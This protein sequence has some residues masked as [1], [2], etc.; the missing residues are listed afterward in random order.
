M[1]NITETYTITVTKTNGTLDNSINIDAFILTQPEDT[2]VKITTPG[3][4][5]STLAPTSAS[6]PLSP[7]FVAGGVTLT[8]VAGASNTAT[9][10]SIQTSS[11]TSDDS[12]STSPNVA[13]I[14]GGILGGVAF[15]I[16]VAFFVFRWWSKRDQ[17]RRG[18]VGPDGLPIT[19]Y[20][21]DY[22][23]NGYPNAAPPYPTKHRGGQ[24]QSRRPAVVDR[25]RHRHRHRHHHSVPSTF[26]G[27]PAL[28]TPPSTTPGQSSISGGMDM[29]QA[30]RFPYI[31][32]MRGK[33]NYMGSMDSSIPPSHFLSSSPEDTEYEGAML[34]AYSR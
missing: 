23:R 8:S 29:A 15:G 19:Q 7:F 17:L 30:Q 31:P 11:I 21:D 2:T 32:P 3:T 28:L 10:A 14:A 5:V 20:S 22:Q 24:P 4:G 26:D 9:D 16:I 18:L 12:R 25:H 13:A 34:P 1:L 6:D 27:A 33:A